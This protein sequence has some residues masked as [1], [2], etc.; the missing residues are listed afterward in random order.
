MK[1]TQID[2]PK[3]ETLSTKELDEINGG[4]GL[5]EAFFWACGY[6]VTKMHQGGSSMS[7]R[8]SGNIYPAA[9][10]F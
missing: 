6:V 8:N 2:I 10:C 3:I 9:M 7:Y 1:N 5:T 4:D